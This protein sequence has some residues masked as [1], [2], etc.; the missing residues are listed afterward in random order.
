MNFSIKSSVTSFSTT[1]AKD[2]AN[3]KTFTGTQFNVELSLGNLTDDL[4]V[5]SLAR[6]GWSTILS[7][8]ITEGKI[9][10]ILDL[11][12]SS[13]KINFISYTASC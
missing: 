3:Q 4:T 8:E 2:H 9:L 1:T 12:I 7:I 10:N 6:S 5:E 11:Y 13:R